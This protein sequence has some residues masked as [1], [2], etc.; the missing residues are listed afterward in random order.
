MPTTVST[1]IKIVVSMAVV[2]ALA[3]TDFNSKVRSTEG[4]SFHHGKKDGLRSSVATANLFC[5]NPYGNH[6]DLTLFLVL[7]MS[8]LKRS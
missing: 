1:T 6:V 2:A 8:D 5:C 3:A 7:R 4:M